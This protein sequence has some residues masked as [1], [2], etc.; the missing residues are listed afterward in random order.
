MLTPT[1]Q[2][3]GPSILQRLLEVIKP[4]FKEK[5]LHPP[6]D[7]NVVLRLATP[8][9]MPFLYHVTTGGGTPTT[10]HGRRKIRPDKIFILRGGFKIMKGG[11][12]GDNHTDH[13]KT[14]KH[15]HVHSW[16]NTQSEMNSPYHCIA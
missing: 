4:L 1:G 7:N 11:V 5:C 6:D 13:D 8:T 9:C 10:L 12:A 15:S 3:G 16:I 2:Q 14:H